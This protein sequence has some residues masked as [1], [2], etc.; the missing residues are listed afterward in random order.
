MGGY[1]VL[2]TG[3]TYI[4]G[5]GLL[6]SSY[7]GKCCYQVPTGLPHST[8]HLQARNQPYHL[9]GDNSLFDILI[10]FQF[11]SSTMTLVSELID[12]GA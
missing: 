12:A 7:C 6:L 5:V 1:N 8:S 2:Y 3:C 4:L 11:Q 10:I 9:G